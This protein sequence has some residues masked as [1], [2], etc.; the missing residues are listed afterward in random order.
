M[1]VL[2]KLCF[3]FFPTLAQITR[4]ESDEFSEGKS[5]PQCELMI[6][7]KREGETPVRLQYKLILSGASA[8][9]NSLQLVLDPTEGSV[10]NS[11]HD[12]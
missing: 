11:V 6:Q 3:T 9:Y 5:I 12:S 10:H 1:L 4:I 7:W 2:A 8:P